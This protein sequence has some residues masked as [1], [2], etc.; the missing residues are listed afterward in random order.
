MGIIFGTFGL[1]A[2]IWIVAG[3]FLITNT[4]TTTTPKA[5]PNTISISSSSFKNNERIPDKFT[6]DGANVNPNLE[7]EKVPSD[8]KSLALVV[9][10][11]D[12]AARVFTHWVL[13]NIDPKTR[14]INENSIPLGS[15]NGTNDAGKVG[16][17]GPCPPNGTHH[18]HFK[19]YALDVD[20]LPAKSTKG[21]LGKV[22]SEHVI[23]E[24]ELVGT[25]S[26]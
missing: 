14:T 1:I 18:Y 22:L 25:F 13:V 2:L 23:S 11:P 9:E 5:D 20:N 16:Y 17:S 26:K 8:T 4:K 10:D 21:D 6:C 24:S 7:I 12:A 19:V 3:S 15:D